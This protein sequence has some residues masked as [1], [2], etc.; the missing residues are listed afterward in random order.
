M[1]NQFLGEQLRDQFIRIYK[2]FTSEPAFHSD[3]AWKRD[4]A[5]LFYLSLYEAL[6]QLE[7]GELIGA[8]EPEFA[9][10]FPGYRADACVTVHEL[11]RMEPNVYMQFLYFVSVMTRYLKPMIDEELKQYQACQ[12]GANGPSSDDW[13]NALS[14]TDAEVQAIER[15]VKSGWFSEDQAARLRKLNEL[16]ERITS[17]PGFGTDDA[18]LIPEVMAA[19][20]R[21]L[22]EQH[23]VEPPPLPRIGEA[24]VPTTL[25]DWE[26]SDA[27]HQIDWLS[28]LMTRGAELAS[29]QPLKRVALADAEGYDVRMWQTRMEIYLDVSGSMPNPILS[30]KCDDLGGADTCARND[31]CRRQRACSLVLARTRFVLGVVSI[32]H[33]DV[34]ISDALHRWRYR[35]SLPTIGKVIHSVRERPTDPSNYQRSGLRCELRCACRERRHISI[36][37]RALTAIDPA[38]PSTIACQGKPLH[39]HGCDRHHHQKNGRLPAHGHRPRAQ[40]ISRVA[41]RRTPTEAMGLLI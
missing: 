21:R 34:S 10:A 8:V 26:Y 36:S 5:F 13:A 32:R 33:R 39:C 19:H 37:L 38:T 31:A 14:P 4:P 11:F 18:A 1:I 27:V 9:A 22:A 7:P 30:A 24:I 23:L 41:I 20:Y 28:T 3:M 35:L 40:S 29:A 15:A 17:L 16:E 25:D 12:C 6:W 2:A